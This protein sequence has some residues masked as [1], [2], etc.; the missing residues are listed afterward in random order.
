MATTLNMT[1]LL[2]RAAFADSC[3]LQE[4]EPGYN[5]STKEFKIGD[6]TTTWKNLPI[7][8]KSQIDTLISNAIS[9]HAAG[10]Y[11]KEEVDQLLAD[12]DG[13]VDDLD[14]R[15]KNYKLL[16]TPIEAEEVDTNEFVDTVAQDANGVITITTKKVDFS[17]YRT[18]ADQDNI[19]ANF[20]T[21]Q[22]EVVETGD[23]LKTVTSIK[24]NENGV[25]TEVKFEDIK[26]GAVAASETGLTTGAT[27]YTAVEAAKTYA[28][29]LV[30]ALPAPIDYTVTCEDEDVEAGENTPAFKRHVLKQLDGTVCTIDV[31]RDMVIADGRVEN[32]KLILELNTGKEIEIAVGDLIEYVTGTT[33]ADGV[34]TVSV[35]P[36]THVVTA[37][38]ADGKIESKKFAADVD[39]YVDNRVD[40]KIN[41]L[42]VNDITGFG[43]GQTLATLTETDGKIA[44]TFQAIAI[45]ESQI[46]DLKNYKE[47]QTAYSESGNTK[48]TITS[49]IQNENGEVVVTYENIDF[50]EPPSEEDFGVLSVDKVNG[51]AI[52]VDN[53]DVQNPKIGLAINNSGNVVL[54]QT[55]QGLSANVDLSHNHDDAYKKLQTPITAEETAKNVFVCGVNQN[56]NGEVSVATKEVDF[57]EVYTAIGNIDVGVTKIIAG[58]DIVVD[59]TSGTGEVTVSHKAYGTGT[60]TKPDSVSDANFVTGINVENGHV[61]GASVKSLADA[62]AAMEFILD[63]GTSA[64]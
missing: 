36:T 64:N 13:Q 57:S 37:T 35:D 8:N 45:T 42:D 3:V 26:T 55:D 2:R 41:A 58:T 24:Q 22:D 43:A 56:E 16:Q 10:Y 7:A 51:T 29:G 4:G 49:V 6:G 31:P 17:A 32:D 39:T 44:A 53:S 30:D 47:K 23:T 20:K 9:A 19:D 34:I 12:L 28:K 33:A 48:Q 60:Y 15:F 62:L 25:I 46:T 50:P 21:K 38:I 40:A 61:T 5:T 59:P 63:G 52:T 1:L 11:T 14:D 27:V 54:S 18:A